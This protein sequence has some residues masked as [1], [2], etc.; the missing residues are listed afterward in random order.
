MNNGPVNKSWAVSLIS[1][2][3]DLHEKRSAVFDRLR[4]LSFRPVAFEKKDFPVQSKLHSHDVCLKA[5]ETMDIVLLLVDWRYG[6]LYRGVGPKSITEMELDRAMELGKPIISCVAKTAWD[7]RNFAKIDI[8]KVSSSRSLSLTEAKNTFEPIYF[9][10]WAQVDFLDKL[11]YMDRDQYLIFFESTHDLLL[12]IENRLSMIS[13]DIC[14][15]LVYQQIK[16][17]QCQRSTS[18][19][20]TSLGGIGASSLHVKPPARIQWS[21][22]KFRNISQALKSLA[23]QDVTMLVMGGPGMGKSVSLSRAFQQHAQ[24]ALREYTF[25]L[26]FF[27]SLRGVGV[28]Y[29]FQLEKYIE[30]SLKEF[31]GKSTYPLMNLRE[32]RPVFYF[33]GLDECPI[34]PSKGD[35]ANFA[36]SEMLRYPFVM[37]VRDAFARRIFDRSNQL[38]SQFKVLC[39]LLHW[40]KV[41]AKMFIENHEDFLIG[42]PDRI[43]WL[44]AYVHAA[45]GNDPIIE[46]P[47]LLSL[48][49]WLCT[50]P[51]WVFLKNQKTGLATLFAAFLNCWARRELER[52]LKS[53]AIGKETD[54]LSEC[55]LNS[56]ESAAWIIWDARRKQFYLQLESLKKEVVMLTPEGSKV[57]N[58]PSFT[59]LLSVGDQS[60][61]VVGMVHEQFIEYLIARSFAKGCLGSDFPLRNYLEHQL[62]ADATRFVKSIWENFTTKELISTLDCL[63]LLALK[64]REE[65]DKKALM[66]AANCTYYISRI[67]APESSKK[68]LQ[69]LLSGETRIYVRNGILF[70]LVRL[71]DEQAEE[72]L[73]K[74]INSCKEANSINRGLHLEYFKDS[75]PD[76][77][78]VP[79]LDD[80]IEDWGLCLN[81]LMSHLDNFNERMCRTRRID[82]LTIRSFLESRTSLGPFSMEHYS[83]IKDSVFSDKNQIGL[84]G[85][86]K[87]DSLIAEFDNLT[88]ECQRK[89]ML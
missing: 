80:G 33:D 16:W 44:L 18:G 45:Q 61:Q 11:Q 22:R 4:D 72:I 75:T 32:L 68:V 50:Q 13:I 57:I 74:S 89:G 19:L 3:L 51:D 47:L 67:P 26:P 63:E 70:A 40:S 31:M 87:M 49:L 24:K 53:Q 64:S 66:I 65:S 10:G 20:F 48:L 12:Q 88:V 15:E 79:P 25:R 84:R 8:T 62:N 41:E 55:L 6:E 85:K 17:L 82:L 73:Y 81:G 35:I 14:R 78:R 1:T 54:E 83:R 21:G 43:Q 27:V 58:H 59:S 52:V 77:T 38:G 9:K 36:K 34:E 86:K 2:D 56:W 28:F 39:E 76:E 29:H 7:A 30:D 69:R 42:D 46:S 23:T 71:G 5:I 60:Q 37:A